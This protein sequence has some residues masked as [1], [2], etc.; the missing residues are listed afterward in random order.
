MADTPNLRLVRWTPGDSIVCR[1]QVEDGSH[2]RPL[3]GVEVIERIASV[4]AGTAEPQLG[5]A[6]SLSP[7]APHDPVALLTNVRSARVYL[8]LESGATVEVDCSLAHEPGEL[9]LVKGEARNGTGA[10]VAKAEFQYLLVPGAGEHLRE[11]QLRNAFRLRLLG[12]G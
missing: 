9:V 1:G 7:D 6:R 11:A 8:A 3:V 2:R 12:E 10:R 4:L 5:M